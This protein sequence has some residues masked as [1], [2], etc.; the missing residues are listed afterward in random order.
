MNRR[1]AHRRYFADISIQAV[2]YDGLGIPYRSP[3]SR[4]PI[5][6]LAFRADRWDA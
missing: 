1:S 6:K 5:V 4:G 2:V 3:F